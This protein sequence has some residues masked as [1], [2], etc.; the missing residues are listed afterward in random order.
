MLYARYSTTLLNL[1]WFSLYRVS[2]NN[3]VFIGSWGIFWC[4]TIRAYKS[5]HDLNF[6]RMLM[7]DVYVEISKCASYAPAPKLIHWAEKWVHYSYI[8]LPVFHVPFNMLTKS[9]AF[10]LIINWAILWLQ[11]MGHCSWNFSGPSHHNVTSLPRSKIMH[12]LF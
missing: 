2:W 12:R 3:N 10:H 4:S 7:P 8:K 6:T 5:P 11:L 9:F 1:D